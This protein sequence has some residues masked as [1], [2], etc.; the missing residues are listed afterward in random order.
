MREG[1]NEG[2]A[3]YRHA[4]TQ[5]LR[6]TCP[7]T[8]PCSTPRQAV[9]GGQLVEIGVFESLHAPTE[10]QVVSSAEQQ[11]HPCAVTEWEPLEQ[12]RSCSN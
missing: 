3:P 9:T 12:Q 4:N 11:P 8:C 1:R 7:S 5:A 2:D 10:K 6:H